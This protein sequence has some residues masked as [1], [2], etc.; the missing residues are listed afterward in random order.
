MTDRARQHPWLRVQR[1]IRSILE[2]RRD[3]VTHSALNVAILFVLVVACVAACRS[4]DSVKP[5]LGRTIEIRGHTYEEIWRAALRVADEHAEILERNEA[6]GVIRAERTYHF[7]G[8][9]GWIGIFIRPVA[10]SAEVY[11]VEAVFRPKAYGQIQM[12]S[13]ER[14][15]LRDIVDTLQGRPLR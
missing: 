4:L 5:G 11:T 9:S 8:D 15:T 14:K 2:V 12:Q 10:P 3:A 6:L 7:M 1:L 13:W